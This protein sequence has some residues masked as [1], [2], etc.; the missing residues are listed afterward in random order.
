MACAI[1]SIDSKVL[2]G[3]RSLLCGSI[4]EEV[5]ESFISRKCRRLTFSHVY[6]NRVSGFSAN[7]SLINFMS[8]LWP[9]RHSH[10]MTWTIF[11]YISNMVCCYVD[12][13]DT[14]SPLYKIR[15]M[16]FSFLCGIDFLSR[17]RGFFPPPP[18]ALLL[19]EYIGS[20]LLLHH[21]RIID[22][23]YHFLICNSTQCNENYNIRG[24]I[25]KS[26]C[27]FSFSFVILLQQKCP[28]LLPLLLYYIIGF[29][30]LEFVIYNNHFISH[31]SIKD[32]IYR[33]PCRSGVASKF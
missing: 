1:Y 29:A 15:S 31:S 6:V 25:R 22:L 28:S 14:F 13:R 8:L 9:L 21:L 2:V 27:K 32:E 5:E 16:V 26:I 11:H 7:P 19:N 12:L 17:A 33:L 30:I 20:I 24:R 3:S 4:V 23:I 10:K 18:A